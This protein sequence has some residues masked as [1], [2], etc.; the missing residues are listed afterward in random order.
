ML[1]KDKNYPGSVQK[2]QSF[3]SLPTNIQNLMVEVMKYY[4]DDCDAKCCS[5]PE[6]SSQYHIVQKLKSTTKYYCICI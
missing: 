5:E 4:N 6:R 1:K 2:S 3:C